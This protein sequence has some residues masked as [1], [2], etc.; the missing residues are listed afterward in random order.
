MAIYICV[1][2][3]APRI[4]FTKPPGHFQSLPDPQDNLLY[5]QLLDHPLLHNLRLTRPIAPIPSMLD[6][7]HSPPLPCLPNL[8]HWHHLQRHHP[9]PELVHQPLLDPYSLLE[10]SVQNPLLLPQH[11]PN[12][13]DNGRPRSHG[14]HRQHRHRNRPLDLA[15]NLRVN[16]FHLYCV[17]PVL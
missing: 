5:R 2:I 17:G 1:L 6:K 4:S 8:P 15:H 3:N 13:G 11:H 7:R 16:I 14:Q 10:K 9:H 12:P